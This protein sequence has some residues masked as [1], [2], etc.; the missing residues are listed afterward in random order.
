[1]NNFSIGI[2]STEKKD[3]NANRKLKKQKWDCQKGQN[4]K[5]DVAGVCKL[6]RLDIGSCMGNCG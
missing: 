2:T 4:R 3:I 6:L 1:M 5:R